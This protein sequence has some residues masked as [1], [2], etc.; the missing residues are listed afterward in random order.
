MGSHLHFL[1]SAAFAVP[2]CCCT[3][4]LSELPPLPT[5][6]AMD[7]GG[8]KLFFRQTGTGPDVVL[9]HGLGDSSVGWQFIEPELVRCWVPGAACCRSPSS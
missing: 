8:H 6:Q 4:D 2:A 1:L 5:G 7:I 9:P 3:P